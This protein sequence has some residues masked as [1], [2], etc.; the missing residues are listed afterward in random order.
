MGDPKEKQD[1]TP[2]PEPEPSQDPTP[3]PE[4][5]PRDKH[6]QPG[7]NKERHDKE[8]AELQAK[9]DALTAQVADAAEQKEK[10]AD[11]EKQVEDL[12]DYQSE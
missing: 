2:E 9:I 5:E 10:R 6:G 8:V 12:F 4:P 11:F 7:I 3:E 1:P